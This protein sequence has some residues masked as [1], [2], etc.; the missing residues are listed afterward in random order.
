MTCCEL[1]IQVFNLGATMTYQ[2]DPDRQRPTDYI[3]RDDGS[4]SVLP[5][6]LGVAFVALLGYFL[7][8]PGFNTTPDRPMIGERTET[9]NRTITPPTPPPA[10]PQ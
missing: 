8:S 4:W 7:F 1:I 9:P 3:R 5:I 6:L 10:K 2:R